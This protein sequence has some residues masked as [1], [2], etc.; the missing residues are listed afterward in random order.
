MQRLVIGLLITLFTHCLSFV[1]I[2]QIE[3]KFHVI[4]LNKKT[5]KV[6]TAIK[7]TDQKSLNDLGKNY[8]WRDFK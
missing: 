4:V 1:Y 5:K 2:K 8:G 7:N 6:A 3:N